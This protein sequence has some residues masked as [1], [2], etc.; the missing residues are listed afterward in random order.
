MPPFKFLKK[1]AKK[2]E[3]NIKENGKNEVGRAEKWTA[4]FCLNEL[5]EIDKHLKSDEGKFIVLIIECCL[6]RGYSSNRWSEMKTK[7]KENEIISETIK[8][9]EDFLEARLYNAGLSNAV[10]STMAIAGLNNKYRWA[11]K[12]E[13]EHSGEIKTKTEIKGITF[14]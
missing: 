13:H 10:N 3:Y 14:D 7:F 5:S 11:N 12:Y 9:I 6:Y 8:R 1:M 2:K 4:E